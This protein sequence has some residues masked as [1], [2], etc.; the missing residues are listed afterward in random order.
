MTIL[1]PVVSVAS[2]S[3]LSCRD[4]VCVQP[5]SHRTP[6]WHD[7]RHE[8]YTGPN[9]FISYNSAS[10]SSKNVLLC[11]VKSDA[12]EYKS[13]SG[14]NIYLTTVI[15]QQKC[16]FSHLSDADAK[17]SRNLNLYLA[18]KKW[19]KFHHPNETSF[20]FFQTA[21]LDLINFSLSEL[22][23]LNPHLLIDELT[24]ENAI[25]R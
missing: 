22:R 6:C 24:V 14:T 12:T 5:S 1:F 7:G 13:H 2:I 11:N 21:V 16:L 10:K 15:Q 25:S 8:N 9:L 20:N 17:E 19:W 3:P 18:K 4:F 23:R